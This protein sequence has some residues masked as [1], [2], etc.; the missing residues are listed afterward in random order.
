MSDELMS[1]EINGNFLVAKHK[2]S[3]V[4]SRISSIIGIDIS[5]DW[6]VEPAVSVFR[7]EKQ[8]FEM[9]ILNAGS[10]QWEDFC[11]S[12]NER[13]INKMHEVVKMIW[14]ME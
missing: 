7:N 13:M 1:I 2:E 11:Y 4:S 6:Y 3:I 9:R 12:T 14:H 10:S 8:K 5:Q